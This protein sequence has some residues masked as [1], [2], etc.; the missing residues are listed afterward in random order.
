ML[1]E[2]DATHFTGRRR[3]RFQVGQR[4]LDRLVHIGFDAGVIKVSEAKAATAAGGT[5]FAA[6][7]LLGDHG[8]RQAH[9]RP[10][11]GGVERCVAD[12]V[13]LGVDPAERPAGAVDE[14][15]S[16]E[17]VDMPATLSRQ[18]Q[19]FTQGI[20]VHTSIIWQG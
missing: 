18:Y 8:D 20:C 5:H 10:H 6:P 12:L 19:Y 16:I 2:R 14:R 11:V 17:F 15:P 4:G 3:A 7:V 1:S 9:Q 13:Q